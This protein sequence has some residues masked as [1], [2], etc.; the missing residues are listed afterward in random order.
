MLLVR[1]LTAGV[2]IVPGSHASPH[3]DHVRYLGVGSLHQELVS[4]GVGVA[5][6][7][8]EVAYDAAQDHL[9]SIAPPC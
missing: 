7:A 2:D 4:A 1:I 3:P 8:Q 9:W 5:E 6:L